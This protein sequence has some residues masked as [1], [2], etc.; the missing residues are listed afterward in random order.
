MANSGLQLHSNVKQEGRLEITLEEV[1][2]PDPGPGEVI[3]RVEA[4]PINP[5]DLGLLVGFADM[6]TAEVSGTTDRPVVN[7]EVPQALMKHMAARVDQ[8]LPVGN[9]GAGIVVEAG[10]SDAAQALIGKTVAII[11]GGMYTQ[12]RCIEA[13][14]CLVLPD[15]TTPAEGASC[16][17]NPLTALGMVETMRLEG[18][19]ALVHTAAASNLGQMLNKICINDGVDLVNIVRKQ[20]QVDLLKGIGAKVVCNSSAD[21]FTEDLTDALV[22]TGATLAFDATGGGRLV[23]S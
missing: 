18:H 2:V 11:G 21:S 22:T 13:E 15:G 16:F 12:Y 19:S 20:E 5:S 3:V 8:P 23:R 14:Q 1:S 7:A 4:A 9:E 10:S 6:T 17:V